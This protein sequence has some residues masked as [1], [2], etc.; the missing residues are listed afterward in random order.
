ML[1]L[2]AVAFFFAVTE[3]LRRKKNHSDDRNLIRHL[4]S[5]RLSESLCCGLSNGC[6]SVRQCRAWAY[7][8]TS[9]P[10]LV[11]IVPKAIVP[12]VGLRHISPFISEVRSHPTERA[13]RPLE[14]VCGREFFNSR[15]HFTENQPFSVFL[16]HKTTVFRLF[17]A[18]NRLFWRACQKRG[19]YRSSAAPMS[20]AH[21]SLRCIF[22]YGF[23]SCDTGNA[24]HFKGR[25]YFPILIYVI[26]L[27]KRQ[28]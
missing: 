14:R 10:Y 25:R 1:L 23:I 12:M 7:D 16:R 2:L 9:V 11:R 20:F 5:V 22:V 3:N 27:N 15:P 6:N 8:G 24:T 21:L 19:R 13:G 17:F 4:H 28:E 18:K 26:Q